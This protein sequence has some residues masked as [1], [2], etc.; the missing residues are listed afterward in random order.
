MINDIQFRQLMAKVS[1]PGRYLGGEVNEVKKDPANVKLKVALCFPDV[2][3]I[4]ESHLGLKILYKILNDQ[5]DILA[6]RVYAPWPDM[7]AALRREGLPLFSLESR[8]PLHEFDIVGITLPYELVYTNV[9]Q[10][11][12]LGRIPIWQKDRKK[13]DPIVIGGGNN[14]F[15]PE[16]MADFFDCLVVGD[17][18]DLVLKIAHEVLNYRQSDQSREDLLLRLKNYEGLYVPSFFE[19]EYA[20]NHGPILQ[21]LPKYSDY[22]G[23]AK[24]IVK[25]LKQSQYPTAPVV[26]HVQIVHDR[27]GVEV[28]R[29]CVRGCRFCQAGYIYRPERQR[30]P[31]QVKSIIQESVQATGHEQV[32]LLSL[33]VGDYA[34]LDPLLNDLFDYYS[35]KRINIGLPAT[36]TETLTPPIIRQM[37]RGKM[38]SFTIAPEAGTARMRRVINK[39]NESADLFRTAENVF[40]EG[41]RSIKLYYM[42]GLPF[43]QEPDLQGIVDESYE[44]HRIGKQFR[45]DV[46]ISTS[47]SS[48]VPKPF[49]PFQWEPQPS[50]AEVESKHQFFREKL[51]RRGVKFKSHNVH[52]SYLEGVFSRGDRRLAASIVRAYELGCRFDEWQEELDFAKWQQAFQDC[53]IDPDFYV[54]R[55]RAQDEILPWDHLFIQM[56]KDW[57][58]KEWVAAHD[59]AFVEDC[60]THRCTYCGV[61]DFKAT[62][63]VNFGFEPIEQKT[64]AFSTRARPL[65]EIP[66]TH[67]RNGGPALASTVPSEIRHKLR[68]QFKK[69]GRIAHLGH[70]ELQDALIRAIRR[71]EIPVAYSE[72]YHPRPKISMGMAQPAGVESL[73]EFFDIQINQTMAAQEFQNRL[74]KVLPQGLEI[75]AVNPMLTKQDSLNQAICGQ[76][77][78]I[79]YAGEDFPALVKEKILAMGNLS[80]TEPV[81][82]T[83]HKAYET[84]V[85]DVRPFIKEIFLENNRNLRLM[86]QVGPQG[87]VKPQEILQA[88]SSEVPVT[89][90]RI[91]KIQSIFQ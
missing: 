79:E 74:N 76:V 17:G 53:T 20:P 28:Q 82:I 81:L 10:V 78:S 86:T 2:Y 55:R 21:R 50:I 18:E 31:E 69:V 24:A 25:E 87:G 70:L 89:Q 51:K 37:K 85:V 39:G 38:T 35:Q 72:G 14:A 91:L 67:L 84:K 34:C 33:S 1:K 27:I 47:V 43:E 83:R 16:P 90:Y 62:K 15:N 26:P 29:G 77:Y 3:D 30:A 61:C 42:C 63:N 44:C 45:Q 56:G 54:T 58:W 8:I 46:Q 57:L 41:F 7:E 71:A 60:S 59:E 19:F 73:A 48:F 11:L 36:R 32:S 52:M 66:S 40:K 65:K 6:E 68:V 22:T 9:L 64:F 75:L 4:G 88:L 49:T 5:P 23:V 80:S 13:G 12:A